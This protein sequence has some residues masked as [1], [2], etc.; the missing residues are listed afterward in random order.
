M[1]SFIRTIAIVAIALF[2][3]SC[4]ST[5]DLTYLQDLGNG[6]SLNGVPASLKEYSLKPGDILY[7]NIETTNPEVSAFFNAE[8]G[9]QNGTQGLYESPANQYIHGYTI[10]KDGSITLPVL[11]KVSASGKT[12]VE[13][14][15]MVQDL[16]NNYLK[17]ALVV[18]KMLNFKI[19]LLG[20]FKAP[21]V[22]YHYGSS[23]PIFEAIAKAGGLTDLS[24]INHLLVLR[25]TASG[26]QSFRV[27]ISGRE[28]LRSQ[29][30][31]LQP[32][33][34]VY[35]EPSKAKT[36]QLNLPTISLVFSSVSFIMAMFALTR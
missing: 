22:Y 12:T 16:A 3:A 19:T 21:G 20:E 7:V 15:D 31:Y 29:A 34:V 2:V 23:L 8:S 11:G 32:Y 6:D 25:K 9:Q 4:V 5:K 35:A 14:Q 30:Y 28:A 1:K 26:T 10:S 18:V 36:L 33:D 13:V 24:K 27:D 17:G